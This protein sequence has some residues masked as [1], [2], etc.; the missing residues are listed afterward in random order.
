M[1]EPNPHLVELDEDMRCEQRDIAFQRL[2]ITI[3]HFFKEDSIFERIDALNEVFANALQSTSGGV[4]ENGNPVYAMSNIA[5]I[6][7]FDKHVKTIN[8][9]VEM[10]HVNNFIEQYEIRG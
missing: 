1:K 3:H 2:S 5:I 7:L 6:D 9:L 10:H 4:D 8:F